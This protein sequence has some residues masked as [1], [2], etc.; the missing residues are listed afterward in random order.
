[1][2]PC[3]LF[4]KREVRTRFDLLQPDI[5]RNVALKQA[6]QKFQHDS[7]AHK[8]ELFVGQRVMVRNL[9]P[10]DK[11]V[12]GTILECTGPLSC[13]VQVSGGQTWK[14]HIDHLRQMTDSPHEENKST[15]RTESFM[16]YPQTSGYTKPTATQD[17]PE[18]P[19]QYPRRNRVAP[20]RLRY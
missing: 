1:M 15:T 14:R 10:G 6:W 16:K 11:W 3:T 9:R 17:T 7:H 8:R 19:C 18:V 4:L 2:S 20:D 12:P 13:L 5:N